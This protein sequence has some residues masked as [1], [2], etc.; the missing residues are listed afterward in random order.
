MKLLIRKAKII[1]VNSKYHEKIVDIF[2][3]DGEIKKIGKNIKTNHDIKLIEGKGLHIAPGLFDLHVNFKDPGYEWKEDIS[4]GVKAAYKGGFT[5]VV[6]MPSTSPT[7]DTKSQVEYIHKMSSGKAVEVY[8]SGSITKD[9]NGTNL[10]EMF[11]MK[12]S[13]AVAFTNDKNSIQHA[14]LMKLALLYSKSFGGIIMNQPNDQNIGLNGHMNE[15]IISTSLGI[16]GMPALAEHLMVSRDIKLVEYTKGRLHFS[17]I[18]T[19]ESVKLIRAAKKRGLNITCD[20]AIHN[21]ILD[22][23]ACQN[24]DTNY[25]VNPA[26]RTKKDIKELIKGLKDG[27]ID[28]ICSDHTPE[29]I[30]HKRVS[31][32]NAHFGMIG[33]Q[34]AFS[35]ACQLKKELGLTTIIEKM[36]INPRKVLNLKYPEINVEQKANICI[37]NPNTEW[38]LNKSDIVSKS[39]NT[40]FIG[41]KL[42]G[43]I[44]G[45]INNGILKF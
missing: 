41:K 23:T 43:K 14:G 17:C 27:T 40:P 20:V 44:L 32:E 5:G 22:E 7:I 19:A 4:S 28:A 36:A 35:L 45:I 6:A 15:G 21:L 38:I 11:D 39:K 26:L 2:I 24:F 1:D 9:L 37:F 16:K 18:S 12:Q 25:K 3:E 42:K 30:E 10:T 8:P 13:G 31:F 29:D 34:T 33:L